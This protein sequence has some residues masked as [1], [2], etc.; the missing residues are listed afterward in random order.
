[1]LHSHHHMRHLFTQVTVPT[2]MW[3]LHVHNM[4]LQ[5]QSI[6]HKLNVPSRTL[7]C[8]YFYATCI[9][10]SFNQVG[11]SPTRA[12]LISM[13]CL[14]TSWTYRKPLILQCYRLCSYLIS[15]HTL[16][17]QLLHI[18]FALCVDAWISLEQSCYHHS[19]Y[20][21]SC[22]EECDIP[23]CACCLQ[24]V[25]ISSW[26]VDKVLLRHAGEAHNMVHVDW[27]T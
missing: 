25:D 19:I 15:F 11:L 14:T 13:Q 10:H 4:Y 7:A 27:T 2:V 5:G 23:I 6:Y 9:Y 3:D 18:N 26:Q 16:Q 21:K 8:H 1:M 24:V 12:L 20:T 17:L 22:F